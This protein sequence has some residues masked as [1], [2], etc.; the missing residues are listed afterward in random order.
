MTTQ[1]LNAKTVIEL[2]KIAKE[3]GVKL[4]A[5][6][7]KSDIVEKISAALAAAE[8][9]PAAPAPVDPVVPAAP[10]PA[11]PAVPAQPAAQEEKP[12]QPQFRQAWSNPSPAPRYSAKPSYQAPAYPQRQNSWQ[13]R[14][15]NRPMPQNDM[16]RTQTVRPQHYTP[17]F[18]PNADEP[19]TAQQDDYRQSSAPVMQPS[20]RMERPVHTPVERPVYDRDERPVYQQERPA[21]S[22]PYDSAPRQ[23]SYESPYQ[24]PRSTV[25]QPR[26]DNAYLQQELAGMPSAAELMT[27]AEC[28]DGSGVLELHPDGYG[29][30]R[31]QSCTP[32]SHDIYIAQA[33]VRRF[34]LRSG[35]MI[36]GKIRPQRDGDKYAAMLYITDIN[37]MPA[38]EM[39]SRPFFEELTPVYPDRRIDLDPHGNPEMDDMR[40]VDLIAPMGFGQ[41]ALVYCP[42]E[43]DRK[44]LL[45]H[46]AQAIMQNHPEAC[47]FALLIDERPEDVTLFRDAVPGCTVVAST[48]GQQPETQLRV[49][50]LLL[51]RLMRLVECGHDVVLLADSLTRYVKLCPAA[52]AQQRGCVTGMVVPSSLH[53][54]KRLFS[55]ARC[56][57]EGGSLTVIATMDAENGS[58]VDEA[59]IEDF[60]GTANMELALDQATIRAGVQPP[61]NLHKSHTNK[62]EKLLTPQQY[63]GLHRTRRILATTAS[64]QAVPQLLSMMDKA[65]SNEEFLAKI[66]DWAEQ[67]EKS[68]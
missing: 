56:M 20:Y 57:R 23:S 47:V 64:A 67:M 40:I 27:P 33:Q 36:T 43:C 45:E 50:D 18:G 3:N 5:G 55:A 58:K 66:S 16:P 6:V 32:S 60:S 25:Y 13:Q 63:E 19:V 9:A 12:A 1:E 8:P 46:F 30:L 54:A 14:P 48:F 21:Y 59:V 35:D 39:G 61:I 15:A 52:A 41:R 29:F 11:Q 65:R 4:G 42:P 17:R 22:Q 7:S 28:L 31:A 10:K 62:V 2:R 37:G 68:R 26:R 38:D 51:E 44:A 53:K 49:A 24:Q 34:G